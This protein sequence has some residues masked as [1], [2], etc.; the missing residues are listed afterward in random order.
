MNEI[1]QALSKVP[2]SMKRPFNN[3]KFQGTDVNP[4]WRIQVLT[5]TFGPCGFGWY[6]EITR[7][8]LEVGC[9]STRCFTNINLYVKDP[10]TKEWSKPIPGTGGSVFTTGGQKASDSDECYKM[11]LTDALSVAMKALGVAAEV[12]YGNRAVPFESKYDQFA[13]IDTP[14]SPSA[15]TSSPAPTTAPT[16]TA[17]MPEMEN[18]ASEVQSLTDMLNQVAA[19]PSAAEMKKTVKLI[20]GLQNVNGVL[21]FTNDPANKDL[22]E[23]PWFVAEI[24]AKVETLLPLVGTQEEVMDFYH[25]FYYQDKWFH[26]ALGKRKKELMTAGLWK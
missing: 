1:F 17:K 3:G 14:N 18:M 22:L 9:S 16:D 24:R 5:E 13:V 15:A 21:A 6:Y 25:Q 26:T 12:Y 23:L 8:W 10:A 20:Q 7:Q 11:S 19:A 2:E 4:M